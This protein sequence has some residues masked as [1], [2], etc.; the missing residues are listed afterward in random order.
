MYAQ[1][2]GRHTITCTRPHAPVANARTRMHTVETLHATESVATAWYIHCGAPCFLA[3][4]IFCATPC[5]QYANPV[6]AGVLGRN[7]AR[8]PCS[9]WRGTKT[10]CNW[11]GYGKFVVRTI[12]YKRDHVITREEAP[13]R[14]T[15]SL[16]LPPLL[17]L[18]LLLT[19][20]HTHAGLRLSAVTP[21]SHIKN[22]KH[23]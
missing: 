15:A 10:P 13:W 22:L 12:L 2:T 1:A 8:V 4:V 11:T 17:L 5:H 16:P 19:H 7:N 14:K 23:A 9:R 21:A 6:H 18:L 20:A 3:N